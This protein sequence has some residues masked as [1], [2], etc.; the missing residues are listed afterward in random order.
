[1][2]PEDPKPTEVVQPLPE[3]KKST[4]FVDP[5]TVFFEA[6]TEDDKRLEPFDLLPVGVSVYDELRANYKNLAYQKTAHG[7]KWADSLGKSGF[8]A[9]FG[10]P[11]DMGQRE[12]S[13]WVR[14]VKHEGIPIAAY[15]PDFSEK[16]EPN[17]RLTGANAVTRVRSL[18]GLGS[19]IRF[20]LYHTCIWVEMRC[21]TDSELFRCIQAVAN[22]K[23]ILGAQTYGRAF[24][25]ANVYHAHHVMDLFNDLL[26]DCNLE[27]WESM[28]GG[29]LSIISMKDIQSIC[30]ALGYLIHPN[31][32]PMSQPCITNPESC[33]NIDTSVLHVGRIHWVDRNKLT[34]DA[35]KLLAKNRERVTLDEVLAVRDGLD[36]HKTLEI[37]PDIYARLKT[38][39]IAKY[40]E[41][42][43]QWF[44]EMEAQ[45]ETAFKNLSQERRREYLLGEASLSTLRYH[46]H[47]FD[48]FTV[49]G[50]I[51]DDVTDINET[52]TALSENKI[53]VD[54]IVAEI[55][56]MITTTTI[57]M[58]ALPK[59]NCTRCGRPHNN[60]SPDHP[61]LTTFDAMKS[62]FTLAVQK[63][64]QGMR[65][66]GN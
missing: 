16:I 27:N 52:I 34:T 55:T 19:T 48:M 63:Y 13:E 12:N 42:G 43:Y 3:P 59:T 14:H 11:H 61:S 46:A 23:H 35:L 39:T 32:Y 47:W 51:M 8:H 2:L 40:I 30:W 66:S 10:G 9:I 37:S 5:A 31:G 45:L 24:T 33:Q 21:P 50:G 58:V 56:D 57:A 22:E 17:Q 54:K 44:S 38:P 20:P 6:L 7:K 25:A 64:S 41:S 60:F 15:V 1:M 29:L 65:K 26:I 49:Q 18:I 36:Q 62:F 4:V 53:Y 28:E